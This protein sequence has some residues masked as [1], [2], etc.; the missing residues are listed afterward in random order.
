MVTFWQGKR[1]FVTGHTGFKG[2][3]LSLWL[4]SL[5]AEVFGFS[6]LPPTTPNLF[7]LAQVANGMTSIIGDIRDFSALKKALHLSQPAIVIHMAAQP[8]VKQAYINPVETYATNVMGTVHLLEIV[9]Q[10]DSIKAIL[11]ITTDKCYDN[12]GIDWNYSENDNLGGRD[13]YSNSKA[14]SELVTHAYRHSYFNE[15]QSTGI[16]SARAGNV[17]GG[18]DWAKD[19]LVPDIIQACI[20]Q[21]P[22]YL[23][24]PQAIRPWQHVL[25]PLSGYLLLAKKLYESPK[26]YTGS[27]NFGPHDKDAKTVAWIANSISQ[28][29]QNDTCWE[30]DTKTHPHEEKYLKLDCTKAIL[31]LGWQPRWDINRGLQE[32]V[33][34]YQ[35]WQS[36][37]NL[38]EKTLNQIKYFINDRALMRQE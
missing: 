22:F 27:W 31:N 8:L 29:W 3:W 32:T 15:Q 18:G 20:N 38:Q 17:I 13:P 2:S 5:G 11:N 14:C 23:R 35:A 12:K 28:L 7:S 6:L 30:L 24:Y 36:S 37:N 26:K 10:M 9:K 19:R 33:S 34:W 25:E 16:A 1:V 4:Q 21:Q